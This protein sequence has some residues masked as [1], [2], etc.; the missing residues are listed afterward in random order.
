MASWKCGGEGLAVKPPI[1]GFW[2]DHY[3]N[4]QF[5]IISLV[6]N[7]DASLGSIVILPARGEGQNDRTLP[8]FAITT[9]LNTGTV[10]LAGDVGL[11]VAV[12]PA[13]DV[14]STVAVDLALDIGP[15][16][17][18]DTVVDGSGYGSSS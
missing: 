16:V 12:V 7:L 15:T 9:E 6:S 5:I 2:C 13:V 18:V 17:A 4:E 10:G 11:I 14:R 8:G 1:V 3:D